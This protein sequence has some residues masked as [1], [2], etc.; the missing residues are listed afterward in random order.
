MQSTSDSWVPSRVSDPTLLKSCHWESKC[1]P[2]PSGH[3]LHGPNILLNACRD[4]ELKLSI[5]AT[6]CARAQL[7]KPPDVSKPLGGRGDRLE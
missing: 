2:S 7:A 1:S 3:P 5:V 6:S 4:K